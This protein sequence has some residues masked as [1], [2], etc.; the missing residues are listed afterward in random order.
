MD[1]F[2][3]EVVAPSGEE[4]CFIETSLWDGGAAITGRMVGNPR[5]RGV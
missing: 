1:P 2:V 4:S 5:A 3:P